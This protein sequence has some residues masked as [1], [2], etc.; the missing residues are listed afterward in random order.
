V[1]RVLVDPVS[2]RHVSRM[3]RNIAAKRAAARGQAGVALRWAFV[4]VLLGTLV[5]LA[6]VTLPRGGPV[7]V[8]PPP[9]PG[10]LRLADGTPFVTVDVAPSGSPAAARLADGS[11][12]Q[13]EPAA[14]I[15][16]LASSATQFVL[17]LARGRATF[18]VV[19][20]GP[21]RW[22]VEAGLATIEVV[23]TEFS[24]FRSPDLVRV[25]VV[26][27]VVLVRGDT[28]PDGVVRL[29]ASESVDVH[30]RRAEAPRDPSPE[31]RAEPDPPPPSAATAPR[32][33]TALAGGSYRDAY[34]TLGAEGL[35]GEASRSEAVEDLFDL[36]DIARLS[37][38]AA[39]AV[40]PLERLLSLHAGST[41]APIA[42]LTLGRIELELR[43][44]RDASAHLEHALRL[45]VPKGLEE[46]AFV[47]LVQAYSEAGERAAARRVGDDS[48]RRYPNGRRSAEVQ[49][50]LRR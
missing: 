35:A 34:A 30:P 44:P 1:N 45:G 12:I 10:P 7:A 17:R 11:V 4:G 47:R 8:E 19:P 6:F 38:H 21:R 37:G 3:W 25:E 14:R 5:T 18:S 39:E 24:V 43:Q 26:H 46:D 40:L 50:W 48:A 36:A 13:L 16:P 32:W 31:T 29:G 49:A 27:G 2:E 20:G 22:L 23:G 28:L 9:A 41:R 15:E 42:A 33:R